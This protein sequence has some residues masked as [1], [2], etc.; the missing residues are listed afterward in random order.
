M[1][2][3][4]PGAIRLAAALGAFLL[5]APGCGDDVVDRAADP[6]GGD[7]APRDPLDSSDPLDP[8]PT[9]DSAV[10]TQT[11]F[12]SAGLALAYGGCGL[13]SGSGAL[14]LDVPVAAD[15]DVVNAAFYWTVRASSPVVANRIEIDGVV[16]HGRL[17][18]SWPTDPGVMWAFVFKLGGN[19]RGFVTAGTQAF[20]VVAPAF[21]GP[22]RVD[23][24]G[25]VVVHKQ[26]G[27]FQQAIVQAVPEFFHGAQELE[28]QVHEL[29]FP[30]LAQ[31]TRAELVL[32]AGDCVDEHADGLWWTFT[33]GIA[34]ARLI[35][36]PYQRVH[37][38]LRS[39]LGA[40]FDAVAIDGLVAPAG[41]DGFA[42]QVQSPQRPRGDSGILAVAALCLEAVA[43][44]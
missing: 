13:V 9:W 24:I 18:A 44:P 5:L 10:D 2:A 40:Q 30:A 26:A 3:P 23:G 22:A 19:G 29:T 36:G 28:G 21:S 1:K 15:T 39:G 8:P 7:P 42:F 11:F 32:L 27:G 16:R 14:H 38:V 4:S 31:D 41:S 17:L 12:D 34:P 6:A 25:V 35:A 20:H 33:Q 43:A 37:D